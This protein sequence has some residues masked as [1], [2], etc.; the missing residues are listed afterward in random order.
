[1][2]VIPTPKKIIPQTSSGNLLAFSPNIILN[3]IFEDAITSFLSYAKCLYDIKIEEKEYGTIKIEKVDT[4]CEEAYR[5]DIS[6][7]GIYINAGDLVGANHAFATLLQM[8]QVKDGKIILPEVIIEDKPD[9]TYR[10]MM[11]DL[12]RNW[13]PFSYL[14]TYVDMCYFYK[15]SV[16]HLHFTDD[17]SYTLPSDCYPKLPTKGRSYTKEQM[18]ELDA[19]A[20]MRGVEIMPE[21]DVP[22]H[23]T[24]F[25][26]AYGELF[27]TKGVICQHE[28]SMKAMQ[29]LFAEVCD[30]FKHS[31]YVHIG[32]DEVDGKKEWANC[33]DCQA[34]AERVGIDSQME[35]KKM[36]SE[37]MYAH[38][39]STMANVCFAKG[40]QPIVW[41]GF[42]KVVNDKISKDI[43]VMSW[44]NYYQVT[45][46]LLEAGYQIMNCSWSPMYVV[47]P[48]A[49]W[50]PEEIYDW[51]IYKWTANHPKSPYYNKTY[52]APKDS[53]ILGGQLLAWGDHISRLYEKVEDGIKEERNYLIERLPMLAEN[54]WN[55]EKVKPYIDL[56]NTADLLNN[57]LKKMIL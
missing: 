54:T 5:I 53:A 34:Y 11:V 42:G 46:E 28:D 12:A 50:K 21:I 27:G 57:K 33:P 47:T 8:M 30:M 9:C 2:N 19:Y 29:E 3:P 18:Q 23:C 51:S 38:F 13:H 55:V 43:L 44:E 45:P 32:G 7:D 6:S 1:M 20:H 10:G 56:A 41:E 24:C 14:L 39:I 25:K 22:G 15:L 17:Q 4:I 40:K 49:M 35:D 31:K 26:F 36:L 16:L 48:L 52:E 37:L